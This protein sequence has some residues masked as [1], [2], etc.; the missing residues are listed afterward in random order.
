MLKKVNHK[1]KQL[2]FASAFV[3]VLSIPVVLLSGCEKPVE[4]PKVSSST[5]APS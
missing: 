1:L 2:R 4:V 3:L 5:I